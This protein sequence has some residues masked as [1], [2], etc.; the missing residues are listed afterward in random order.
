MEGWWLG[1]LLV[2]SDTNLKL[3]YRLCYVR[4]F[5]RTGGGVPD[6]PA[7]KLVRL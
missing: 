1:G 2:V 3:V 5:A 7:S 4:V 6:I